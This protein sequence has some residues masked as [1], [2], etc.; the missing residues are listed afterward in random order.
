MREALTSLFS[1]LRWFLRKTAGEDEGLAGTFKVRRNL[2]LLRR[3]L[4]IPAYQSSRFRPNLPQSIR[5]LT[6]SMNLPLKFVG[7]AQINVDLE[8]SLRFS[9]E[10]FLGFLLFE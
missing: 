1:L 5:F 8:K 10:I 6:L 9:K 7:K 2:H 3:D 4:Q